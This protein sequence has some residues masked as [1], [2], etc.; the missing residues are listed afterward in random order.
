MKHAASTPLR[1]STDYM[2]HVVSMPYHCDRLAIATQQ[3]AI[4]THVN[5]Q[6]LT[7][8]FV[9]IGAVFLNIFDIGS[10]L[11]CILNNKKS[12]CNGHDS[13]VQ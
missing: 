11:A 9:S 13:E 1:I 4:V 12:M 6:G 8:S 7:R 2:E 10:S 3:A 5:A